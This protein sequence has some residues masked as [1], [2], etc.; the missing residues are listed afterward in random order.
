MYPNIATKN[1]ADIF[2]NSIKKL[3]V[4]WSLS[5]TTSLAHVKFLS[6]TIHAKQNKFQ[7]TDVKNAVN[8]FH[9]TITNM[10]LNQH[11]VIVV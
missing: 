8:G 9:N 3:A 5:T 6:T 4:A 10:F 11:V 2:H 7:N 1:A